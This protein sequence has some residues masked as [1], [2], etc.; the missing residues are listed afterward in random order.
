MKIIISK[1]PP[2]TNHIYAFRSIRG[3]AASYITKEGKEWFEFAG[4]EL[5][6]QWRKKTPIDL[7]KAKDEASDVWWYLNMCLDEFNWTLE[8]LSKYNKEKLDARHA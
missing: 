8:E 6:K 5:K 3:H 1:L 2:T 4:L 7:T